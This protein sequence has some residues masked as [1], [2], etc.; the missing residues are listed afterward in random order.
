WPDV[1]RPTRVAGAAVPAA[2]TGLLAVYW[3]IRRRRR[4][5]LACVGSFLL[6]LFVLFAVLLAEYRWF[7]YLQSP[8]RELWGTLVPAQ[9]DSDR[10]AA[11]GAEDELA[12]DAVK[13]MGKG[14][15]G[16]ENDPLAGVGR[17]E[18]LLRGVTGYFSQRRSFILSNSQIATL[19]LV[20]ASI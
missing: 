10:P 7:Q 15:P 18:R 19:W 1:G 16:E 2:I 12:L 6:T 9:V 5:A 11:P 13:E 17:E 4:N 20:M 8:E 3:L 14:L